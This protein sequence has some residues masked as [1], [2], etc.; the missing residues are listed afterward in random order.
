MTMDVRPREI[1]C[2][3]LDRVDAA[4]RQHA[5]LRRA[6]ALG[7]AGCIG[8][9]AWQLLAH[10]PFLWHVRQAS[11]W[12][13]GVEALLLA[14][15]L[16]ALQAWPR[17][18][19]RSV[20]SLL[21]VE[22]YL[23]RHAVDA[24]LL[25]DLVYLELLIA[26]GALITRRCGGMRADDI[27][28]YL[29]CFVLGFAAWSAGAWGL[30][31]LGYGSVAD[32]R[33]FT[34]LLLIPAS[35]A[36]ARPWT[37]FVVQRVEALPLAVRV[38]A[39]ALAAWFLILFAHSATALGYDS[40]WYG[41]RGDRV[42]VGAGSVFVSQGLISPVNY[43]PKVYEL[44]L[45]P[46]S[47]LGS[48]SVIAGMSILMLGLIAA[49][50]Y[51][52]LGR[53]GLDAPL[54]RIAGAAL[55]VTLPAAANIALEAKPDVLAAF[56]LLL[57]WIHAMEFASTRSRDA[58]LWLAALLLL[59]TQAKLTAIPYAASLALA[60]AM[61]ALRT[62]SAPH[63]TSAAD[64]RAAMLACALICFVACCAT[65]RTLLLAGMPTIGPDPLVR[66]WHGAGFALSF[67]VG[68][69]RWAYPAVWND[70][71]SLL[72]DLLFAPQRLSIIAITWTGNVWLWLASIALC[73]RIARAQALRY[74]P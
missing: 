58:L 54:P 22:L 18:S 52:L 53:L 2:G 39:A 59:A 45:V 30:S 32:L 47:G 33:V 70:I 29:R 44:L 71:P 51:R 60:T 62:P 1:L 49:V 35:H 69:L 12:Q 19:G 65:A 38:A 27:V 14:T 73:A 41:L 9:V 23:R 66:L 13:G 5:L 6:M 15:A 3:D 21:L 25:I 46:L 55:A 68:T 64:L 28:G 74:A 10:G 4:L 11:Y 26:L 63:K 20:A 56:L 37:V 42:L 43:F 57:A 16:A 50:A 7:A 72:A 8:I 31:A 24:A 34:A 67:P 48:S 17:R 36:R 40:Q 61:T